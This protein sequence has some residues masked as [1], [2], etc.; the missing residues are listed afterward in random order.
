MK[1]GRHLRAGAVFVFI[2]E[3]FFFPRGASAHDAGAFDI[4]PDS[5]V[6]SAEGAGSAFINPVFSDTNPGP[7]VSYMNQNY[8]DH[9]SCNH[10]FL[11]NTMGFTFSYIRFNDFYN[12]ATEDVHPSRTGYFKI[13]KGFFWDNMFGFGAD[14]SFCKSRYSR[15]DDYKSL[16]LGFLY[17]PFSFLSLGYVVRDIN[18]PHFQGEKID[19]S[20][21][22]SI[23]LSPFRD[24]LT[25]SFDAKKFEGKSF[26]KSDFLFTA[27]IHLK[28]GIA[29]FAGS[30]PDKNFTFGMSAPLGAGPSTLSIEG[31]FLNGERGRPDSSFFGATISGVKSRS[32]LL[33]SGRFLKIDI[34]GNFNEI[35]AEGIFYERGII[36]YDILNAVRTAAGD[37]SIKGIILQI[38]NAG[39]GFGRAQELRDELKKF[40]SGGKKVYSILTETGNMEY[41]LAAASDVIFFSP[42]SHFSITGLKAEVYFFKKLLDKIGI[43]YE[44]VKSG[45]YKSFDE[46]FTREHMSLEF[47]EN[48]EK[49]I[50]DLN[51]Q[52]IDDIVRDRN[53]SIE[54]IDKLIRAGAL[55]PDEAADGGFVDRIEYPVDALMSITKHSHI[56]GMV[57]DAGDYIEESFVSAGWGPVPEI[58]VIYVS[59]S[60]IRGRTG[61]GMASSKTIGDETYRDA[62]FSAFGDFRVKAVVIR[63]DSPGGSATASDFMWHYLIA[64]KKMYPHKPVVFS[65]GNTA[66]SGGYFIS[67]TGD[68]IF[69]SR[70]TVTGSIGVISGKLSLEKL[71]ATLGIN[72]DV[73]KMSEFADIYSE[74]KTLSGEERA[75]IQRGVDYIYE[76]FTGKVDKYRGIDKDKIPDIAEGRVF[77]GNQAGR[78]GLVDKIGGMIAAIEFARTKAGIQGSYNVRHLPSMKAP[79][80]KAPI[81]E[82]FERNTGA[83]PLPEYLENIF[84]NFDWLKFQDED[85]V[86]YFPYL[87]V[88]K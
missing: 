78:N 4:F 10:I 60:I 45:K 42:S 52:F 57:V 74:S 44:S 55:T 48:M 61:G 24:F 62:V 33:N 85:A 67:S 59:G 76:R 3:S 30:D 47:R 39:I 25:L 12:A 34:N 88:I 28:H 81:L 51:D 54:K 49:L 6:S 26:D 50:A 41:Y 46:A 36:F 66:A 83:A 73:I 16:S 14:Y 79:L 68:T 15:F 84:R 63:V 69:S 5:S 72:K 17:R 40:R 2:F 56:P 82:F 11:L 27:G 65:F 31:Y 8:R 38:D 1:S 77:T 86:Y 13:G 53:L 9:K 70:G 22:Y 75:I 58:A 29:I 19:R 37:A 7:S 71:Y 32:T 21:I 18:D 87:V 35:E 23:S 80:L 43:N 64:M 20:E